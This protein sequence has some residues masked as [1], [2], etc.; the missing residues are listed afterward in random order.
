MSRAGL[1]RVL[2]AAAAA[3]ALHAALAVAQFRPNAVTPPP[4]DV[5]WTWQYHGSLAAMALL[6]AFMAWNIAAIAI[7]IAR[8]PSGNRRRSG[9]SAP[10]HGGGLGRPP[11]IVAAAGR[12]AAGGPAGSGPLREDPVAP[13]S[14]AA[15]SWSGVAGLPVREPHGERFGERGTGV[16]RARLGSGVGSAGCDRRA[17]HPIEM[18]ETNRAVSRRASAPA[19]WSPNQGPTELPPRH[20]RTPGPASLPARA[21]PS[22]AASPPE[23]H[24]SRR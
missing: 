23:P 14:D 3:A 15:P 17:V 4:A 20:E 12:R 16:V 10:L 24:P 6:G 5:T 21:K 18:T 2:L 13:E 1:A 19:L 8:R 11:A 9:G 22:P 7:A